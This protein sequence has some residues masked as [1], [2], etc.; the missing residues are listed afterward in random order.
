VRAKQQQGVALITVVMIVALV[1]VLG[2]GL[3][4]RDGVDKRRTGNIL[5]RDQALQFALGVETWAWRILKDDGVKGQVDHLGEVWA[6]TL[7]AFNFE[8]GEVSGVIS[9]QQGLFNLNNLVVDGKG[10]AADI[11][12]MQR[13]L[14][15]L[16][17]DPNLVYAV[18]D[19]IDSDDQPMFGGGAET[20]YYNNLP[21]PYHCA[22]RLMISPSE[23]RLVSGWDNET[24]NKVLPY[25]SALPERSAININTAPAEVLLTLGDGFS[26][27]DAKKI[28]KQAGENSFDS[29]TQMLA[30][31]VFDN[32]KTISGYEDGVK[33]AYSVH[34]RYFLVQSHG[35]FDYGDVV[36]YTL[37]N[38]NDNNV[39]KII[40]R[41]RGYY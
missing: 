22:N 15:Y 35:I 12:R 25:V 11:A 39:M 23:L 28:V 10:S 31:P 41:A 5:H 37:I 4:V 26:L 40:Y 19:W 1:T 20:S 34:T 24:V 16:E 18:V 8:K 36:L 38:R 17:L 13:L 9:D 29:V 7:P 21:R 14:T 32:Y 30:M 2:A 3:L 33:A 27:D 6:Y